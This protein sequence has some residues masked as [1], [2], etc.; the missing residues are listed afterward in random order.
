MKSLLFKTLIAVLAIG[1]LTCQ[2]RAALIT[3]T[4][5]NGDNLIQDQDAESLVKAAGN[6]TA[7]VIQP[8]DMLQAVLS[9]ASVNGGASGLNNQNYPGLTPNYQLTALVQITAKTITPTGNTINIGGTNF[10]TYDI[11]FSAGFADGKTTVQL[12]E[13]SNATGANK[14]VRSGAGLTITDAVNAATSGT[15]LTTLGFGSSIL[16]PTTG[17]PYWEA[18]GVPIDFGAFQLVKSNVGVG[19]GFDFAQNVLSNPG[20]LPIIAGGETATSSIPGLGSGTY[21]TVGSGRLFGIEGQTTP[22]GSYTNT[23]VN[24]AAVV[25]PEPA[26]ITMLVTGILGAG[27]FSLLRRRKKAIV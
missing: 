14:L 5:Q 3:S 7:N 22:F 20:N 27:G 24:F 21:D 6:T 15:L 9:F 26:S 17:N 25:T 19:N 10:A 16:G 12:Y 4:L 2:S 8:G 23:S 11:T 1:F 18:V 13:N